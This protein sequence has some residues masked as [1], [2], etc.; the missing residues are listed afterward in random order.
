[1]SKKEAK[2]KKLA[3][4]LTA[5][6]TAGYKPFDRTPAAI[7]WKIFIGLIVSSIFGVF[8]KWT[9]FGRRLPSRFVLTIYRSPGLL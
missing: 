4:T 9:L 1:M 8:A 5:T 2:K 7:W 6:K 3:A